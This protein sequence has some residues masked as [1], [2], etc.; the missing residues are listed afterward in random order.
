MLQSR[1]TLLVAKCVDALHNQI[2]DLRAQMA[3]LQQEN[4]QLQQQFR[5]VSGQAQAPRRPGPEVKGAEVSPE[6][7]RQIQESLRILG[8]V[9]GWG[10]A[11]HPSDALPKLDAPQWMRQAA[12]HRDYAKDY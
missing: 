6:Q 10:L 9:S 5:E 12:A 1:M 4:Q 3:Q 2:T 7:K 11:R 8:A